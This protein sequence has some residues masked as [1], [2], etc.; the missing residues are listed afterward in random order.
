MPQPHVAARIPARLHGPDGTKERLAPRVLDLS[1]WNL[2]FL[3]EAV[4][5]W[6]FGPQRSVPA[7]PAPAR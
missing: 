5:Q 6:Q 4:W 1:V 3:R 7:M 2:R